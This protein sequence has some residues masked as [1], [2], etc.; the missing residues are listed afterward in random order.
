[1][2]QT[3]VLAAHLENHGDLIAD[4]DTPTDRLI[5]TFT[6]DA[7]NELWAGKGWM[8]VNRNGEPVPDLEHADPDRQDEFLTGEAT[9][10]DQTAEWKAAAAKFTRSSKKSTAT[11]SSTAAAT[12]EGA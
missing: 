9:T 3:H 7:F 6:V 8:P 4:P 12:T 11:G 1:M 5:A 10:T 2:A